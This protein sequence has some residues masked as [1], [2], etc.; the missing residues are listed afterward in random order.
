ME[1]F[2]EISFCP[3]SVNDT[4]K[5]QLFDKIICFFKIKV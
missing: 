4:K 3:V 2:M 5:M 1:F